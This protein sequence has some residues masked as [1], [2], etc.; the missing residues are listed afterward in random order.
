MRESAKSERGMDR[1]EGRGERRI[2]KEE[3]MCAMRV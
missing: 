3:G 1:I 2:G